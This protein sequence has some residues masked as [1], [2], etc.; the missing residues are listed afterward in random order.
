MGRA[1]DAPPCLAICYGAQSIA[2]HMG[3]RV[4]RSQHREY[5]RSKLVLSTEDFLGK[6]LTGRPLGCR[7]AIRLQNFLDFQSSQK[8]KASP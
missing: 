2:H 5:G 4:E 7:M 8:R 6:V 3:G 1:H